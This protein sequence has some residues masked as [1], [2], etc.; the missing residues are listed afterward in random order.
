MKRYILLTLILILTFSL[1][2]TNKPINRYECKD[3]ENWA[4]PQ[5][6][7][8]ICSEIRICTYDLYP[9]RYWNSVELQ[10]FPVAFK[11]ARVQEWIERGGVEG[12]SLKQYIEGQNLRYIEALNS[13]NEQLIQ[14]LIVD[15]DRVGYY[16][17]PS[18]FMGG[19]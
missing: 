5:C 15:A 9:Q 14:D 8:P 3:F 6:N 17:I 7:P 10:I 19:K 13:G 4:L 1:S 18:K 16:L 11:R 2:C 12:L